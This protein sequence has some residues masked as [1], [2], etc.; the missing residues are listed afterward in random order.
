MEKLKEKWEAAPLWQKALLLFSFSLVIA[1]GIYISLISPLEEEISNYEKEKQQLESE[2][3]IIKSLADKNKSKLLEAK[4]KKME[5]EL[6]LNKTKLETLQSFIPSQLEL[7]PL[8]DTVIKNCE[9]H[10][11]KLVGLGVEREEDVV[12]YYDKQ[13]NKVEIKV[14]SK[15]DEKKKGKEENKDN[16]K[17]GIKAKRV[18]I[19]SFIVGN[20]QNII[21]FL[22]SFSNSDRLIII[23]KVDLSVDKAG[24]NS[25]QDERKKLG[26]LGN[27]T[28]ATYY[29]PQQEEKNESKK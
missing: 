26:V 1:Y 27:I 25:K 8:F 11:L 5:E 24:I 13:I 19:Q 21:K 2:L 16:I 14:L 6:K 3:N 28:L 20:T 7:S 15:E 18:Y 22:D 29:I 17:E 9:N 4:L 23:D 12:L 10:N